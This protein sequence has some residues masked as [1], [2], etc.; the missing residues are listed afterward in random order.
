[1]LEKNLCCRQPAASQPLDRVVNSLFFDFVKPFYIQYQSHYQFYPFALPIMSLSKP[2]LGCSGERGMTRRVFRVSRRC[3]DSKIQPDPFQI[4]LRL[5]A[6]VVA[7]QTTATVLKH[8]LYE[9]A[10]ESKKRD[11]IVTKRLLYVGF[12]S[13]TAARPYGHFIIKPPCRVVKRRIEGLVIR[14]KERRRRRR[15]R[16]K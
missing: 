14:E 3:S 7:K 9:S 10:S 8:I 1:M 2:H 13:L 12:D 4:R 11:T 6:T 16:I 5:Q 15:R